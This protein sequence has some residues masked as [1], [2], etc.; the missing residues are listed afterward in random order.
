MSADRL[1]R[2]AGGLHRS[3]GVPVAFA[4]DHTHLKRK[5]LKCTILI[6]LLLTLKQLTLLLQIAEKN[7]KIFEKKITKS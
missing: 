5:T 2:A 6:V 4:R 7:H 3:T 1:R